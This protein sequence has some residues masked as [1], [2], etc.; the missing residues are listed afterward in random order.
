M[1]ILPSG[2]LLVEGVDVTIISGTMQAFNHSQMKLG[3]STNA[4]TA[5]SLKSDNHF[6]AWWSEVASQV[7]DSDP[8]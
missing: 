5:S 2:C 1:L 6:R 7:I 8:L 3:S 4:T